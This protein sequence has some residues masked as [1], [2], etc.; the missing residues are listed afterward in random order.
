MSNHYYDSMM[1]MAKYKEK[2]QFLA[3]L[4]AWGRRE[5]AKAG[6]HNPG[7]KISGRYMRDEYW[8]E[9]GPCRGIRVYPKR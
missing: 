8:I 1:V 5:L 7:D 2:I 9:I 6:L 3:Q 4:R